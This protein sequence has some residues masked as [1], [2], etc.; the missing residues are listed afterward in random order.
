M[1]FE[2]HG[3]GNKIQFLQVLMILVVGE[4]LSRGDKVHFLL[5]LITF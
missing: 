3:I 5:N 2:W 1:K 4:G